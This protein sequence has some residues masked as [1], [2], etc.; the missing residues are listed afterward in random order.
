MYIIAYLSN[1]DK[2]FSAED[3]PIFPYKENKATAR[4]KGKL[5]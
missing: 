3:I 4:K 5:Y 2:L 1:D